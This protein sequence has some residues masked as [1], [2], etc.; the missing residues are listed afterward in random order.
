MAG[1]SIRF[2]LLE[3]QSSSDV[4]SP[5]IILWGRDEKGRALRV[6]DRSFSP[7]FFAEPKQDMQEKEMEEL[8]GKI[9]ELRIDNRGPAD[10]EEVSRRYLGAEKRLLKIVLNFIVR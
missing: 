1:G 8:A 4:N 3:A 5:E 7:Y 6:I 2:Y 10:V 9:K